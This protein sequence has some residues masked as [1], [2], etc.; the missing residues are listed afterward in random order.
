MISHG[1]DAKPLRNQSEQ[2]GFV[3]WSAHHE[4]PRIEPDQSRVCK[5]AP[6]KIVES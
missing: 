1:L 4:C 3:T 2:L 6:R 5:S